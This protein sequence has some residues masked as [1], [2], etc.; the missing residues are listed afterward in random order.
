M[1]SIMIKII[2]ANLNLKILHNCKYVVRLFSS[3]DDKVIKPRNNEV[4]H[5]NIDKNILL[6]FKHGRKNN[7]RVDSVTDEILFER[8]QHNN[9]IENDNNIINLDKLLHQKIDYL[10][11][12]GLGKGRKKFSV[13]NNNLSSNNDRKTLTGAGGFATHLHSASNNWPIFKHILPEIAF[14]GHS[15]SGKSTLVNAIAGLH[16]RKGPASVSDRAGWTDQICFYQL[17][18]K[19]PIFIL[20]DLP[21]YG[22]AITTPKI[23]LHWKNSTRDYLYSRKVL[24][25]CC[26]L[27]DCTR[28]LCQSDYSL[29]HFLA[30]NTVPWQIILTKS[31]LL[32]TESLAKSMLIVE[33]DLN[34]K[35]LINNKLFPWKHRIIIPVSASSGAG[36][37]NLFLEL[38]ECANQ[39]SL[40][41]VNFN[42]REHIHA[43][44]IRSNIMNIK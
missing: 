35:N 24:S 25:R 19:P 21:G 36:I 3:V 26:V 40:P 38:K 31:D 14:S 42:V 8:Y 4:T 12:L 1:A 5:R 28:G 15:N 23:K 37:H 20:A 2:S 18:K 22:H 9:R 44:F 17:G 27:V 30:K 7:E 29:I 33:D 43:N 10:E 11:K 16:P 32:T 39:S 41:E 34:K 13:Y 6:Q